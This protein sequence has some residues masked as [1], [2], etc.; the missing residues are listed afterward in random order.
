MTFGCALPHLSFTLGALTPFIGAN[1]K[2]FL[3]VSAAGLSQVHALV[4]A[5]GGALLLGAPL[6][7]IALLAPVVAVRPTHPI[8]RFACGVALCLAC[9]GGL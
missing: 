9:I 4:I 6:L 8:L 1:L 7:C 2:Y 3:T 5:T